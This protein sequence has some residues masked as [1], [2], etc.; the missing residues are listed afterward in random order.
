[1][2]ALKLLIVDDDPAL[3][4]NLRTFFE[5]QNYRVETAS[6]GEEA[7]DK[8]V[9]FHP[10]LMFLDIGLPGISGI[11]VLKRAKEKEPALRV[12]M[13]TGQEELEIQD[14]ASRA[15]ADDYV[16]KPFTLAYLGSEVMDKL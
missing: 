10:H 9:S 15:G 14:E 8:V 2:E 11:E 6:N 4:K 12:I 7:V 16:K 1:M 3:R 5:G 13:I